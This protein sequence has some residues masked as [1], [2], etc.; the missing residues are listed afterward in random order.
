[1]CKP[2]QKIHQSQ[3]LGPKDKISIFIEYRKYFSEPD[4]GII[5]D[6]FRPIIHFQEIGRNKL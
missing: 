5:T 2:T 1:M 6:S 4:F 3:R